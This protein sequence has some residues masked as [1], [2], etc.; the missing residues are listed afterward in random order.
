MK[1]K[2]GD[3]VRVKKLDEMDLYENG[4][5]SGLY[6]SHN[7]ED[8][9]DKKA[10]ITHVY[11]DRYFI[12]IGGTYEFNDEMLEPFAENDTKPTLFGLDEE[13]YK[14]EY[15]RMM[16]SVRSNCQHEKS[17]KGVVCEKCKAKAICRNG[18]ESSTYNAFLIIKIVSEWSKEHP[19]RT[20][21]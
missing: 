7:M 4:M 5:V 6:F 1:Y 3:V 17:C 12:D 10:V 11:C 13:T 20:R 19:I 14:K 9:C 21:L 15:V 18:D 2:V 16:D 8:T